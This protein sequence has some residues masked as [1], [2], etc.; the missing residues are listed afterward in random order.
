MLVKAGADLEASTPTSRFTPLH[1]ASIRGQSEVVSALVEAGANPNSRSSDG[2]TPLCVA[3]V[4]GHLDAIKVLLRADANPLLTVSTHFSATILPLGMAAAEGHLEVIRELIVQ[5]GLEGCGGALGG[6]GA[7]QAASLKQRLDVMGMLTDAG[8]VDTGDALM[9][10]AE[11]G[12]EAS[13]KFLLQQ[14]MDKAGGVG[15]AYVNLR[16]SPDG[17]TPILAAIGSSSFSAAVAHRRR[18][19]YCVVRCCPRQ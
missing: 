3:A 17:R 4:V 1:A 7:L 18:C 6:L 5:L 10:A 2:R 12:Q 9:V 11:N 14:H 19:G 13:V 16:A 8:V 15:A